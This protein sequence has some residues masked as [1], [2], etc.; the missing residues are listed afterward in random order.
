MDFKW[1]SKH[2]MIV[3]FEPMISYVGNVAV[4]A[5]NPNTQLTYEFVMSKFYYPLIYFLSI[6]HMIFYIL[7]NDYLY[8]ACERPLD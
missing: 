5:L 3:K 7:N 2:D 6:W 4:H 8:C 1:F